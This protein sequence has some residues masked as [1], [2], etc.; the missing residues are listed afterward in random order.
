MAF[1]VAGILLVVYQESREEI[2]FWM[3]G[4]TA[5]AIQ[6]STSRQSQDMA[7]FFCFTIVL[8]ILFRNW[9]LATLL[10]IFVSQAAAD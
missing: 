4:D 5:N 7:G 9:I 1:F 6:V 8:A 2:I 10:E 3:I